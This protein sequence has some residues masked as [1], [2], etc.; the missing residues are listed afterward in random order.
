MFIAVISISAGA[1]MISRSVQV[2][3]Q[4]KLPHFLV[5]ASQMWQL[6]AVLCHSE[7]NIFGFMTVDQTRRA[8]WRSHFEL[9]MGIFSRHLIDHAINRLIE[10]IITRLID[11]E[12]T[13][14]HV[15]HPV[16]WQ[17][18][19]CVVDLAGLR[20]R[21][22]ACEWRFGDDSNQKATCLELDS[23]S[24]KFRYVLLQFT[25]FHCIWIIA[26]VIILLVM[27]CDELQQQESIKDNGF[28]YIL[29]TWL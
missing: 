12:N 11:N 3:F 8:V 28:F 16:P 7:V 20:L 23:F 13:N 9:L 21:I 26:A 17:T 22:A 4:A 2:I 5:P 10:E 19:L 24:L 25:S 27:K 15:G 18:V 14:C 1:E 29:E 6:A